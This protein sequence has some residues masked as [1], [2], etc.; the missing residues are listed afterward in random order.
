E[1]VAAEVDQHQVLGAV[2]LGGE[3][4]L[5][6]PRARVRRPGYRVEA[7]AA[8]LEL[9]ERLG[10]RADERE[11]VELEQE[12][13]RRRVDAAQRPVELEGRRGGRALGPLREHDLERLAAADLLL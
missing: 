11:A 10:G 4:P 12:E 5:G 7:G 1:V 3:Q 9:D 8:A 6:V 13:V 2:L